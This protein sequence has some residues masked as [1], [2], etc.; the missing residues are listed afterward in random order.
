VLRDVNKLKKFS[1]RA[2]IVRLEGQATPSQWMVYT[3]YDMPPLIKDRD[4]VVQYNVVRL[5]NGNVDVNYKSVANVVPETKDYKRQDDFTGSW[6]FEK[7]S[8]TRTKVT[9]TAFGTTDGFPGWLVNMVITN[10][11][12]YT[13][14]NFREE[15]EKL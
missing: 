8:P 7:V 4:V 11:P 14:T 9:Y 2:N 6:K 5:A 10:G 12:K 13:M 15:V 3:T 1:Y